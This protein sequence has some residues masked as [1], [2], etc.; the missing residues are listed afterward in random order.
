MIK[1]IKINNY[2]YH[3]NQCVLVFP[4]KAYEAVLMDDKII[5]EFSWSQLY[6]KDPKS[7]YWRGV[8]CYDF[9]GN[10]L[11]KVAPPYYIDRE[12]GKKVICENGEG[13]IDRVS[14]WEAENKI[15]VY[16][17]MGYEVDPN[18]GELGDIVWRER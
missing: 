11:W 13:A 14:Y 17:R 9:D 6:E 16:G 7:E 2:L 1:N 4:F 3:I 12:S 15:V 5:V 18:T 10:V 8:W